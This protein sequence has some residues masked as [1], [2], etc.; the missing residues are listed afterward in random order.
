M[1][2]DELPDDLNPTK[3]AFFGV[4]MVHIGCFGQEPGYSWIHPT[5]L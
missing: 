3:G 1:S 4:Y 5:G 2:N